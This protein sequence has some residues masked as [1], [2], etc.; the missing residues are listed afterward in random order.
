MGAKSLSCQL[1]I[2]GI[3]VE[4]N[5]IRVTAQPLT[6]A[7]AE[8]VVP[9]LPD[10]LNVRP[11]MLVHVFYEDADYSGQPDGS[12]YKL[13]FEGEIVGRRNQKSDAGSRSIVL[14]CED[15]SG[16]WLSQ[17]L[18][19]LVS[20]VAQFTQ[21]SAHFIGLKD[22]EM[23]YE[24][25]LS[26][27]SFSGLA[28]SIRNGAGDFPY[29]FYA[30]FTAARRNNPFWNIQ[31]SRRK[32]SKK[33]VSV[34][35][36]EGRDLFLDF[37]ETNLSLF[38]FFAAQ[39]DR[40]TSIYDAMSRLMQIA[41]Y[42]YV[43][44]PNPSL[45]SIT[46]SEDDLGGFLPASSGRFVYSATG[47]KSIGSFILKPET[48]KTAP[49]VCNLLF[50]DQ[51]SRYS[52]ERNFL[53]EPTRLTVAPT[54]VF[55]IGNSAS[56]IPIVPYFHAPE[57]I[58]SRALFRG[59]QRVYDVFDNSIGNNEWETGIIHKMVQFD[60][61]ALVKPEEG[62]NSAQIG[63]RN[64]ASSSNKYMRSIAGYLLSRQKLQA[65]PVQ[66]ECAGFNPNLVVDFP[67][68]YFDSTGPVIFDI[69]GISHQISADGSASTSVSGSFARSARTD[70]VLERELPYWLNKAFWPDYAG[71]ETFVDSDGEERPGAHQA[72][73]GCGN[74]ISAVGLVK[75]SGERRFEIDE[76]VPSRTGDSRFRDYLLRVGEQLLPLTTY[77]PAQ[78]T[79]KIDLKEQYL[80]DISNLSKVLGE[81]GL[82]TSAKTFDPGTIQYFAAEVLNGF[83]SI[84]VER[85][86]QAGVDEFIRKLTRRQVVT[87]DM[88]MQAATEFSTEK[89]KVQV[90]SSLGGYKS[91][92]KIP[93]PNGEEVIRSDYFNY[94]DSI[95]G[96]FVDTSSIRRMELDNE[97]SQQA[98]SK[99]WMSS[100][101]P[102]FIRDGTYSDLGRSIT[103]QLSDGNTV[104]L[105]GEM[106]NSLIQMGD[107]VSSVLGDSSHKLTSSVVTKKQIQDLF[108]SYE[109][110]IGKVVDGGVTSA[111]ASAT[112]NRGRSL[113]QGLVSLLYGPFVSS[114]QQ[115]IIG[116]RKDYEQKKRAYNEVRE[117]GIGALMDLS[118]ARYRTEQEVNQIQSMKDAVK[119][120]TQ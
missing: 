62:R 90:V 120:K 115:F 4:F 73:L 72:L 8:I 18:Y 48:F 46:V 77:A 63:V 112:L 79:D 99:A 30:P 106:R 35:D 54:S 56:K 107:F 91:E 101:D 108:D 19:F 34:P 94:P 32:I 118:S 1:Y 12:R 3:Q 25:A 41:F 47:P 5:S 68:C 50:P 75:P 17:K 60:Y 78:V 105:S 100:S 116:I 11:R 69:M 31:D 24:T 22:V 21:N 70:S 109:E 86:G 37:I 43:P 13:L 61:T 52:E 51:V 104:V 38:A 53:V 27:P 10:F 113:V 119:E 16:Y 23:F 14:L 36:P 2:E 57:T 85:G 71:L 20:N 88:T 110:A 26:I 9:P 81:L 42:R 76:I 65:R 7:I 55:P 96:G 33:V 59:N 80:R 84:A 64:P 49:P 98:T 89:G 95:S 93:A 103:S 97:V 58:W 45:S 92:I 117:N 40:E 82:Q 87:K 6:P 39:E 74:L 28:D 29:C 111:E 66:L 83:Y 15:L 67:A 44:V 114:Y 102:T